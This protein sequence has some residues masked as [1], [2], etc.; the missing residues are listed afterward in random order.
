M[1]E[2]FDMD[3]TQLLDMDSEFIESLREVLEEAGIEI[4]N[5]SLSNILHEYEISKLDFLKIQ[6]LKLLE[7]QEIDG[8]KVNI[9]ALSV[10]VPEQIDVSDSSLESEEDLVDTDTIS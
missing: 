1:H 3:L 9:D 2:V 10:I 7:G 5:L 4:D 8:K 6:I